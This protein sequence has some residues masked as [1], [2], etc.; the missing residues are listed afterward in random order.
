MTDIL[1]K[2]KGIKPGTVIPKPEAKGGFVVKG[3]GMRRGGCALVY[4]IPNHSNP[5]KPYQ[6]GINKDEWL[7][8]ETQLKTTGK[9]GRDWFNENMFAC[10]KEGGC[11]FTTIG[12]I[13][14]LL[15]LAEYE[16]GAYRRL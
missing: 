6:K 12:G 3:W 1:N 4:T 16:R 2:L 10:A 8:A 9:F 5:A 11:N 7:Q 14:Q 15:R 13:F